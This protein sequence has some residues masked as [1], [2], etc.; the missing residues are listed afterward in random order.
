MHQILQERVKKNFQVLWSY[1]PL[2]K[3]KIYIVRLHMWRSRIHVKWRH[4][5]KLFIKFFIFTWYKKFFSS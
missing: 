3:Y 4:S 2:S 1:L 5:K